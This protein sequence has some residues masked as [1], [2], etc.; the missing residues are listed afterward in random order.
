MSRR[1]TT[2]VPPAYTFAASILHPLMSTLTRHEW[3]GAEHLPAT[4]GFLAACN[5]TSYVD[6][7]ALAHFLY[8][9]DRPPHF[10][11]KIEVFN[12]PV[13]GRILRKAE[14]IPVYRDTDQAADAF[15][16]AVAAI[17]AGQ[18][19]AIYPEG[20]LTRDPGLWP[21]T[22]KTGTARI[23]LTTRCPVVPVGQWGPQA[24]LGPYARVPRPLPRK[25]MRVNAGPPVP[26]DDL[27]DRPLDRAVLSEATD[28]IMAAIT[29]IV[30]TL[31]GEPAPTERFDARAHGLPATGNFHD[32]EMR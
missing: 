22:A 13:V 29:A 5:H 9:N 30:E 32:G 28:R 23:A 7:L 25:T 3:H 18:C 27:Y 31:R 24:V 12:V 6:P 19:I 17:R 11:G 10:L 8:D 26:L 14:Q 21:M 1:H 16:A 15:R 2:P 20:T 4:G